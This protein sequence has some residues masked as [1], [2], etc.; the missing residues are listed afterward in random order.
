MKQTLSLFLTVLILSDVLAQSGSAPSTSVRAPLRRSESFFGLH[1]DF[2]AGAG[3]L[4]IGQTLTEG[5][6]D[7]LLTLVKPDFIQVDC[8][9][10]PGIS[11]YPSRV[12]TTTSAQSFIKNPLQLFRDVTRRHGVAL[13]VHYSGVFDQAAARKFPQWAV[14]NADGQ[15]NP[16]KMSVHSAYVDSLLIPQLKEIADYGV[17]GVWVDGECWATEP[18]YSPQA[19]A[20]FRARTGLQTR[21]ISPNDPTYESFRNFARQ[22]FI[23]YVGHYTDALHRYNP[24]FQVCSN[25]AFSSMMPEPVTIDVDFL[26]GD[27]TPGNSVNSAVLMA[28][29][30]ASQSRFYQ[31]PYDLMAWGFYHSFTPPGSSGDPK[32]ALQLQQ[33]AAEIMAMGGGVQ[34]YFLQNRDASISRQD[35]PVMA[36]LA[37][38][39]RA[40]QPYCQYTIA[41]PQIAVLYSSA[42]FRKYNRRL[43]DGGRDA[44]VLGITTALMDAQYPTEILMEHHLHG[45][46]KRYGLI[47]IPEWPY[48]TDAFQ[49]ELLDY[50]QGGGNLLV[51]GAG[52]TRNFWTELGVIPAG[53]ARK[54]TT[55]VSVDGQVT[56]LSD[57]IQTVQLPP[58]GSALITAFADQY[59]KTS[60]GALA[61]S[62]QLG[63]GTITGLYANIGRDYIRHQAPNLRRLVAG[64][65]KPLFPNPIVEISGTNLVHVAVNRLHK[66][67]AVNLINTGGRHANEE[68]FTYDEVPPL[69]AIKVRLRLDRKPGRIV[70]Q[71]E[72]KVLPFSYSHGVCTLTVPELAVH[73]IL[74]VV[75]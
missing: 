11:S 71:P 5:R 10:H 16:D 65:V 50:V 67:L 24:Q 40:R 70:Q 14:V 25:W 72:N 42:S 61:T 33:E 35:W 74:V 38:F 69:Q 51:I 64:L 12:P 15:R 30:M 53:P 43:Y 7:S 18:D 62:R 19:L 23:D 26:S 29:V 58:G 44:G 8:K 37:R 32:T 17:D 4:N 41:V 60:E 21:P 73:S 20:A 49:K 63:K 36:E 46:M 66:Q 55:W 34:S 56:T 59:V 47:V 31:K 45:N 22:S 1:F 54:K 9:G 75:N 39:I 48:L 2:H 27:L 3:D 57:S 28:R 13:Y 52:A 6:I 68:V